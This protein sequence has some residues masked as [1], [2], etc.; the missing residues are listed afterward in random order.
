MIGIGYPSW[1]IAWYL[2][3][4]LIP[5][6]YVERGQT[7]TF[8]VEGG[9]DETQPARYHPFYISDSDEGGYGQKTQL[10]QSR[11]T[12]YAGVKFENDGYPKPTGQFD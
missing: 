5:E 6:L 9:N 7:Y 2:N 8:L 3:D 4:L 10:K 1:G 12:V 11:Q